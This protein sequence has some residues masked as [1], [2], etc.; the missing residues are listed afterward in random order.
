MKTQLLSVLS[1][2]SALLGG[3]A[4][5]APFR[6]TALAREGGLAPG[7]KVVVALSATEHRPGQ[8]REFFRDTR[9]VLAELPAQP[10]LVGYSFRFEIFGR[11]AWTMTAWNDTESLN[12][13][14]RSPAHRE[15]VR[16]SDETA[17][18]F[19]FAAIEVP[20]GSLPLSWHEARLLVEAAEKTPAHAAASL[21]LAADGRL[22]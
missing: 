1:T 11:T 12:A 16:R 4:Y 13:F 15:A 7:Q 5:T 2:L 21:P 6:K 20:L 17:E 8:R 22:K 10:G 19:R 3:C 18:N 9:Q 14:V